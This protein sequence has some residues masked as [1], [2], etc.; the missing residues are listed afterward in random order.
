MLAILQVSNLSKS[1][2][3]V[4][5]V[6]NVSLEVREG[7]IVGLIGPNG[8]GKTTLFNMISHFLNYDEGEIHFL[9]QSLSQLS[10]QEIARMGI[11]RTFQTPI[12]FPKLSCLENLLVVPAQIGEGI[13]SS[14]YRRKQSLAKEREIYDKAIALLK[15]I[16]LYEKR[17]ELADSLSAGELK[18]LELSRQLMM[19]PKLLM[20]DEPASGINPAMLER[21]VEHIQ[22]LRQQGMTFLII[23][24][25]LG[26]IM[27]ICDRIYVLAQGEL[28]ASGKPEEI[29]NDPTV[30]SV[31]LGGIND[32]AS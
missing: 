25:N 20:L 17:N 14:I 16:N 18:L 29:A 22:N 4:Q 23:D 21:M 26:F 15:K 10:P 7:E 12:G 28:I 3:G 30:K 8:A 2:G 13:F 6:S 9:N 11:L 19:D 31:Y 5:A 27:N 1:F 32:E 24:H